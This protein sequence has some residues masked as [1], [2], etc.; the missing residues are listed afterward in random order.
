MISRSL[1]IG[2]EFDYSTTTKIPTKLLISILERPDV[3]VA[4]PRVLSASLAV[5]KMFLFVS[6][7]AK[8]EGEIGTLH[9]PGG[10]RARARR[11]SGSVGE[12]SGSS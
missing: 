11:G 1:R 7:G 2:V 9:H 4:L 12:S 10:R 8:N 3:R 5:K 6:S